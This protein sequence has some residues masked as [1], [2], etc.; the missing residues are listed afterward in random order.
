[1]WYVPNSAFEK[2]A[3]KS[4]CLYIYITLTYFIYINSGS[5]SFELWQRES[6]PLKMGIRTPT[7]SQD[8]FGCQ[9]NNFEYSHNLDQLDIEFFSVLGF[10]CIGQSKAC[11][12]I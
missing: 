7:Q 2:T 1:M 8:S 3:I 10:K 6:F 5:K 4:F 12:L 11:N 9:H